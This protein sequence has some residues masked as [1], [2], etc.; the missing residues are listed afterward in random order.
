M[1]A[2]NWRRGGSIFGA[3]EADAQT[4]ANLADDFKPRPNGRNLHGCSQSVSK[5]SSLNNFAKPN[6]V[7][8]YYQWVLVATLGTF[9]T[10]LDR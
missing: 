1:A 7:G 2:P 3:F 10:E 6:M 5:T 8:G 9:A 4:V